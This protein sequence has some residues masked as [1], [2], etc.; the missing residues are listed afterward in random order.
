M[1]SFICVTAQTNDLNFTI[2][3]NAANVAGQNI[4]VLSTISKTNN[5]ITW[6]QQSG[7]A[8][9]T[10]IFSITGIT[11]NSWDDSNASGTLEYKMDNDGY[12]CVFFIK[13][14]AEN[15]YAT[16]TFYLSETEQE[17]YTFY[18]SNISYQ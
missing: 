4:A 13:G 14:T 10:T 9:D 2:T 5:T 1:L 3:S 15:L 16:I 12:H 7:E 8:T 6:T 11:K 18:I 17:T